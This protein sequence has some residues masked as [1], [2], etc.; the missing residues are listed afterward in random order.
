MYFENPDEIKRLKK[1]LEK[2][3]IERDRLLAE[4]NYLRQFTESKQEPNQ[5]KPDI[6]FKETGTV[7]LSR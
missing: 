6:S 3:T 2:V 1:E 4:N 5:I 7:M